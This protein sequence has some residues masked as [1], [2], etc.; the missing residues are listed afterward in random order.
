MAGI[1]NVINLGAP[2]AD[3][4][5]FRLDG[6]AADDQSGHSVASAG[7]VNG[8]GYADLVVGAYAAN[9]L[10]GRSYVVY[11]GAT[12]PGTLNLGALTTAQGFR[13]DGAEGNDF[14]GHSVASAGDVNGDGYA[15]LVVGAPQANG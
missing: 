8:D 1:P 11:G 5:L 4:D 3:T 14:S 6:A 12:N 2:T 7:D 9:G 13:L 10:A 15:D